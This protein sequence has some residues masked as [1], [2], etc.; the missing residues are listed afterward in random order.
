M[1][2]YKCVLLSAFYNSSKR[3]YL[4]SQEIRIYL[5][6][7]T[8]MEQDES[9]E[10]EIPP[11]KQHSLSGMGGKENTGKYDGFGNSPIHKGIYIRGVI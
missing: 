11:Q 9:N 5:F 8:V 7:D 2:F 1:R 10:P 4:Y 6:S 3:S